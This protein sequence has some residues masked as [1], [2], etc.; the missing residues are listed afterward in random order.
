[1]TWT[2][3]RWH[4]WQAYRAEHGGLEI[5]VGVSAGPRILRFGRIGG[6]NLLV[7]RDPAD[8]RVGQWRLY[9]GHRLSVAPEGLSSYLPD[10][11]PCEVTIADSCLTAARP[12]GRTRTRRAITIS[13]SA[14]GGPGFDISH[15][16]DYLG[17]G[18]WS[19]ALWAITC[20]PPVGRVTSPAASRFRHWP[21]HRDPLARAQF[22]ASPGGGIV[23]APNLLRTK[24]GWYS[25]A[26]RIV[27]HQHDD[28]F[29]IE[30]PDVS[31]RSACVDRGCNVEVFTC[32]HFFEL[33]TL[34]PRT[35]LGPGQSVTHAQHWRRFPSSFA[36]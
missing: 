11:A 25:P 18:R 21:Q 32:A 6:P 15:R 24:A 2:P 20:V 28:T 5:V 13:P 26:G 30:T 14:E 7:D 1:M 16:L 12:P 36:P 27:H 23:V 22:S 34:G 29:V 35:F 8:L 31:P 9:G 17:T 10:N 19:G 3:T 33:E 4:D